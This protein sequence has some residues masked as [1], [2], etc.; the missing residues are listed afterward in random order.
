MKDNTFKLHF[1]TRLF[2]LNQYSGYFDVSI[3]LFDVMFV[4]IILKKYS[5]IFPQIM[6]IK[7]IREF[8]NNNL[9]LVIIKQ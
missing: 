5:K 2:F 8:N 6:M 1:R 9:A 7:I 4:M 3:L